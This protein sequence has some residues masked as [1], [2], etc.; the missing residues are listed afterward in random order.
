MILLSTVVVSAFTAVAAVLSGSVVAAGLEVVP[1][2]AVVDVVVV[3][4]GV[5]EAAADA[6]AVVGVAVD[7]TVVVA[8]ASAVFSSVS[9]ISAS[10]ET[11]SDE[12]TGL[13]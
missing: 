7:V 13:L 8:A 10:E 11:L 4:V 2:A 1:A 9:V 6:G 12:A 3:A 5:A